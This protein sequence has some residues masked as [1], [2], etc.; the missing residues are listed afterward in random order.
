MPPTDLFLRKNMGSCI[1]SLVFGSKVQFPVMRRYMYILRPKTD[2]LVDVFV[3]E[4]QIRYTRICGTEIL[5]TVFLKYI[6]F[7]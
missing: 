3:K 4:P 2:N 7:E 1:E 6:F 5:R